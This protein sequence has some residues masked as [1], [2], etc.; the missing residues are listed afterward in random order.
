[1]MQRKIPIRALITLGGVLTLMALLG[2]TEHASHGRMVGAIHIRVDEVDGIRFI[3]E[4][5]V[6]REVLAHGD[7]VIGVP[8]ADMDIRGIEDRLRAIPCISKAEV[9]LTLDGGLHVDVVQRVPVIRIVPR[10]GAGYYV[11]K[12]GYV[13]PLVPGHAPRVLVALG[14][15]PGYS[16]DRGVHAVN[17]H[18]GDHDA[19]L[20]TLHRIALM[21]AE[22]PFW[23]ALI[24]QVVVDEQGQLELIPSVGAQRV[25]IGDGVAFEQR[26]RKLRQYYRQGVAQTDWRRHAIIDLRFDGQVVCTQRTTP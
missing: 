5:R 21:L 19:L 26:L 25:R 15:L 4:E 1:M 10:D 9:Y 6:R 12:E 2:F 18:A 23:N 11:D 8:L 7:A 20:T 22:D 16:S 3:D 13:M 17:A 24:D 14:E